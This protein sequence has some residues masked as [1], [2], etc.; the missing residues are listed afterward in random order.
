MLE[1]YYQHILYTLAN[2]YVPY[3]QFQDFS[4]FNIENRVVFKPCNI[5]HEQEISFADFSIYCIEKI[6]PRVCR[7]IQNFNIHNL[8]ILFGVYYFENE[9]TRGV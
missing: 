1:F 6:T 4:Y 5:R 8:Y 7:P 9:I 2:Y 3:T